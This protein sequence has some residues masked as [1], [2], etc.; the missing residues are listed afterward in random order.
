MTDSLI[1]I[2][3]EQAKALQEALKALRGLGGFLKETFG[4]VPQ[5]LVGYLGGDWLGVRR[6][7]NLARILESARE[8]LKERGVEAAEPVSLSIT[9]PIL[10]AAAEESRDELQ[11][12]WARLLAAAADPSR[13]KSF[14][15]VFV[16]TVKKMDPLDAA[17]LKSIQGLGG[18]VTDDTRRMAAG[19]LH[20]TPDEIAVSVSNLEKLE[21]V[22]PTHRPD[23]VVT[24]FG[25]ELL[26]AISN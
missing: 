24:A 17:T 23:G 11:D 8:R 20:T 13:A 15:I 21:L 16:T 2:T 6:A 18:R 3:D 5:D 7:E 10:I 1:P 4:T 26:R 12:I 9:L 14:R 22:G 19:Q 25:R